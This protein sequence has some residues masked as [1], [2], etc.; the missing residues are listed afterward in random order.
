VEG[1]N[2]LWKEVLVEKYG[3]KATDLLVRRS[4][5]PRFASRWWKDLV[6]LEGGVGQ[7]LFNTEVMRK[8][9]NGTNTSFWRVAW[10]GVIHC[11]ISKTFLYGK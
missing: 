9:D 4:T 5:W 11:W 2:A 7:N 1:E 8:V 3:Q 10:R 6:N